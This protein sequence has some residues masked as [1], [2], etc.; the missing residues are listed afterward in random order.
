MIIHVSFTSMKVF[1]KTIFKTFQFLLIA[2]QNCQIMTIQ[3]AGQSTDFV[4]EK[5]F[6][7]MSNR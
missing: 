4:L 7:F 6:V 3:T 1:K 5:K 2:H